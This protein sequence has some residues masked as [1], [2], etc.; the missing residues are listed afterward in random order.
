MFP[1]KAFKNV[2]FLNSIFI[3][4]LQPIGLFYKNSWKVLIHDFFLCR[5]YFCK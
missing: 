1:M 2:R 4:A 5:R 3:F